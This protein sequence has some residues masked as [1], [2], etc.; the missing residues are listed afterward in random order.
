MG[1]KHKISEYE[2]SEVKKQKQRKFEE[3]KPQEVK[4]RDDAFENS[5][6]PTQTS[7]NETVKRKKPRKIEPFWSTSKAFVAALKEDDKITGK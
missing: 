3:D 6:E 7:N 4:H 5:N 1:T 2:S